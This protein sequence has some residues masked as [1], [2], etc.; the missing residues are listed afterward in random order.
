MKVIIVDWAFDKGIVVSGETDGKLVDNSYIKVDGELYNTATVYHD[1][2]ENRQFINEIVTEH[3]R[4]KD[5][6]QTYFFEQLNEI[7][8]RKMRVIS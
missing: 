6:A 8:R 5:I 4:L 3:R 7:S 2:P 1:T